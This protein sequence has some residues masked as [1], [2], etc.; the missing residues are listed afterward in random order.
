MKFADKLALGLTL[1]LAALLTVYNIWTQDWQFTA[2]L[3]AETTRALA[4]WEQERYDMQNTLA[5]RSGLAGWVSAYQGSHSGAPALLGVFEPDGTALYATLPPTLPADTLQRALTGEGQPRVVLVQDSLGARYL[6]AAGL[7]VLPDG[8][9]ALVHGQP[10]QAVWAARAAR[11]RTALAAGAVLLALAAAGSRLLCRRLTRP[12]ARLEQTSRQIAA[13]DYGRRTALRTGDELASLSASF[14]EMA[15]AVQEK[16]EQLQENLQAREDFV[17]AFTHELKT[18]ITS[19]LGYADLLRSAE[20]TP[21]TRQLAAQYIYQESRRLE[22]LGGKLMALMQLAGSSPALEPT[23]LAA[24][25][26]RL[27]RSL[28]PGEPRA[29]LPDTDA[30]V[31]ADAVLLEDLL[32]N[33]IKNARTATP[34]DGRVWVEAAVRGD[35]VEVSVRDTGCG[36]PARDLPR[37]CEPFYRVDKSRARA[38]GGSGLG[39]A[40]CARIAELHGSRLDIQS[41]EGEGTAVTLCL[42]AAPPAPE[43]EKEADP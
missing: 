7:A 17:A 2:D 13:G 11:Q 24:V 20:T 14:D 36:I 4:A 18:P 19:M 12:L 28:P 1:L 10:L 15:D 35:R 40:L 30:R 32:Y 38:A 37:I 16:I 34:A 22:Q 9:A 23:A 3:Q 29:E 21:Q 31:L 27:R 26:Y 43:T 25:F 5:G 6:L 41:R 42:Q 33:L 8:A 39:L